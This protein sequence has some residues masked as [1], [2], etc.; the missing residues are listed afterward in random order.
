MLP[1][2]CTDFFLCADTV[3]DEVVSAGNVSR[4]VGQL[5]S[6]TS[7]PVLRELSH[8]LLCNFCHNVVNVVASRLS[9]FG[10]EFLMIT[11]QKS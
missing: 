11:T 10:M 8:P 9:I 2:I 5:I 1:C 6:V 4:T 3:R 7:N